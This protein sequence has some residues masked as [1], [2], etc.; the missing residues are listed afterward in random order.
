M[1]KNN[2]FTRLKEL[3]ELAKA[4]TPGPWKTD[5]SDGECKRVTLAYDKAIPG[6]RVSGRTYGY[7]GTKDDF[8]C[9]LNDREYHEYRDLKEQ[10]AN[11]KFIAAANPKMVLDTVSAVHILWDAAEYLGGIIFDEGR[12]LNGHVAYGDENGNITQETN[13]RG[14]A[15]DWLVKAIK[16]ATEQHKSQH[17][18]QSKAP[19]VGAVVKIGSEADNV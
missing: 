9:D 8:I 2:F 5:C 18:E 6:V 19:N 7:C 16:V 14:H 13:R 4:A 3:K 1:L 15:Y 11:A 12:I 17:T 10:N